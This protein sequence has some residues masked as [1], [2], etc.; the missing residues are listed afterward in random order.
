MTYSTEMQT[1]IHEALQSLSSVER[2]AFVLRHVEGCSIE[3]IANALNVRSGA[4]R[5]SVFRAVEKMRKFLA[6]ALRPAG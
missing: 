6:P 1:N 4:A 5:Q 2:T 3:E